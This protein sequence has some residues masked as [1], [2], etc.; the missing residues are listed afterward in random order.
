MGWSSNLPNQG[1]LSKKSSVTLDDVLSVVQ[2]HD[3]EAVLVQASEAVDDVGAG[4]GVDVRHSEVSRLGSVD[5]PGSVV[6][7]YLVVRGLW[8]NCRFIVKI[9]LI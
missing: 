6:A 7:H 2:G 9:F 4:E 3:G 8:T 1:N 5:G